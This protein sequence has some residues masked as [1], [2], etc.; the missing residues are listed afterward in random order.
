MHYAQAHAPKAPDGSALPDPNAPYS[1]LGEH[2]PGHPYVHDPAQANDFRARFHRP[3]VAPSPF[4]ST[5]VSTGSAP[6]PPQ[7]G[8]VPPTQQQSVSAPPGGP[9]SVPPQPTAPPP[10]PATNGI[11]EGALA[12]TSEQRPI[13]NPQPPTIDPQ[14]GQARDEAAGVAGKLERS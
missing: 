8:S 13:S 9:S 4:R 3:L 10:G 7:E 11:I 14:L 6:G 1:Q 2:V 12:G 5:I